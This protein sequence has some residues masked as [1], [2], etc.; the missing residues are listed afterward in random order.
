M[1]YANR[2]SKLINSIM[3]INE[4]IYVSY[5]FVQPTLAWLW[6]IPIAIAALVGVVIANTDST[7]TTKT[8]GKSL[9][10]LGMQ[11]A[12]KTQILRNLQNKPYHAY[13]ATSTDD[14]SCFT[15]NINGRSI[16]FQQGRDIGGGELYIRDYYENFIKGKDIILFVFDVS[17]YIKNE[18]YARDVR[19]RLDFIY[20]KLRENRGDGVSDV[21][22][23]NVVF[24]KKYLT[25]GSH[26]DKLSSSEQKTAISKLQATVSG[27]CYSQMFHNNLLL[28]DLT[29]RDDFFKLLKE[30]NIF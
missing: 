13:E 18:R 14:Y 24:K 9:G 17:R 19:D 16:E 8:E 4:I 26:M 29:K 6:L 28:C 27:K 22:W 1:A 15:A 7:S 25:I 20:R 2:S 12:G 11:E 23:D 3:M 5:E 21:F 10:I 30:K